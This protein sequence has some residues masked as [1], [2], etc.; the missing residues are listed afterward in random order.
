M[1]K[2]NYTIP[3]LTPDQH[4]ILTEALSI[5]ATRTEELIEKNGV[6]GELGISVGKLLD[7]PRLI[8]EDPKGQWDYELQILAENVGLLK[9]I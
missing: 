2:A 1:N 4:D 3:E 7:N 5:A 6:F 9:G 8:D